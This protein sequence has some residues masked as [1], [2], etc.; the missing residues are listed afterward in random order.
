MSYIFYN[1]LISTRVQTRGLLELSTT[2]LRH[3]ARNVDMCVTPQILRFNFTQKSAPPHKKNTTGLGSDEV[4]TSPI[5]N[6][7]GSRLKTCSKSSQRRLNLGSYTSISPGQSL[8]WSVLYLSPR[9]ITFTGP[10]LAVAYSKCPKNNLV[11]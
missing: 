5:T 7:Y 2:Q 6:L 9:Y 1:S 10:E 11:R 4:L 3:E 8:C